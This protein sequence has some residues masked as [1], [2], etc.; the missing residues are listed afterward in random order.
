MTQPGGNARSVSCKWSFVLV[1]YGEKQYLGKFMSKGWADLRETPALWCA[2][3][4]THPLGSPPRDSTAP[5]SPLAGFCVSLQAHT[6]LGQGPRTPRPP[7]WQWQCSSGLLPCELQMSN[8]S[9]WPMTSNVSGVESKNWGQGSK[10]P[11]VSV[12]HTVHFLTLSYP[13]FT[14]CESSVS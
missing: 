14:L 7:Q 5:D 9:S 2:P 12:V 3:R 6:T 8:C 13:S 10:I 4:G 1:S 11:V